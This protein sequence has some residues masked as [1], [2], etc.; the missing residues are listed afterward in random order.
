MRA[1]GGA[2]YFLNEGKLGF[3]TATVEYVNYQGCGY[4]QAFTNQQ[5]NADFKNDVTR[6]VQETY[7]NVINVRAGAEIRAGLLRLRAG[8]GYL[9]SAYKLD[10]DR[11]AKTDRAKLLLS[12]GAGVRNERF[13]ADIPGSYLAYKSGY[14]PFQLPNDVDT[15]TVAHKQPKH[16]RNAVGRCLFSKKSPCSQTEKDGHQAVLSLFIAI[17]RP[18]VIIH[19]PLF[20]PE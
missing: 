3:L 20:P 8:V 1:S 13:F 5:D 18:V 12:A 10:L 11:V 7:Q 14:S 4:G 16:E 2:A 17:S 6:F 9:P 19:L 15:P